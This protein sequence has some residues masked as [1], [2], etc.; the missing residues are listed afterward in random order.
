MLDD[1]EKDY[2]IKMLKDRTELLERIKDV[3]PKQLK[4]DISEPVVTKRS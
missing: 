2:E 4:A 1:A 3:L